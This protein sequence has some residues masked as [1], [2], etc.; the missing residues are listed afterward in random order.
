MRRAALTLTRPMWMVPRL[1]PQALRGILGVLENS[2]GRY[3]SETIEA[4]T[5]SLE[6]TEFWPM[7]FAT[8]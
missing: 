5:L 6:S 1:V 8:G 4:L 3:L 7:G 2:T